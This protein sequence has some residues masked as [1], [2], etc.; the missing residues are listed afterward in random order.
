MQCT[1]FGTKS[2]YSH[3]SEQ[4]NIAESFYEDWWMSY[5]MGWPPD[6][7]RMRHLPRFSKSYRMLFT[8]RK[9]TALLMLQMSQLFDIYT[10]RSAN[11][12]MRA[13]RGVDPWSSFCECQHY[14]YYIKVILFVL[15]ANVINSLVNNMCGCMFRCICACICSKVESIINCCW[16]VT[17]LYT[18]F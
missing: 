11:R 15:A 1:C 10:Y 6:I 5:H 2:W 12:S 7:F 18:R 17:Y 13:G 4:T 8:C 14:F 9:D 3:R 16:T